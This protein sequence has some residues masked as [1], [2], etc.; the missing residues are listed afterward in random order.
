MGKRVLVTGATG[1]IGRMTIAPLRAL[2]YEVIA[3]SRKANVPA[4]VETLACDLLDASSRTKALQKARAS[5]LLHLAWYDGPENRWTAPQNRDWGQA[6]VKLVREFSQAGG[7]RV[8]C[9]GS[10]AEYDWAQEVLREDSPLNPASLYGKAKADTSNVVMDL[11]K[12]TGLSI[13]WA[14]AFFCYGPGEPKGRLLGDLL[15]GLSKGENVPC[16]DGLQQRDFLHSS[17]YGRALATVLDSDHAGP[18]NI[19]SGQ[20]VEVRALITIA[21]RLMGAPELVQLGALKRPASDA[22]CIRAD[23]SR[24]DTLGFKPEFCLKT[25]LKNCVEEFGK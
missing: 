6:T 8:V 15:L 22:A 21:A 7:Q 16:T 19:A 3:L 11:A 17:D 2:G 4:A 1:L 14:R 24:L 20:A 5:H 18:V 25:G 9:M 23:I 12:E 13:A 10:C